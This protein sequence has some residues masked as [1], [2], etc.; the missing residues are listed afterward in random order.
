MTIPLYKVFMPE[1]LD[2]EIHNILYSGKLTFGN[3]GKLFEKAVQDFL[4]N[5]R[6]L[7]TNN[8][9]VAIQTAFAVLGL[10][11]GDEVIASPMS[12]L[13][14]NQP[15]LTSKLKVVWSD[16][17]PSTGTLD[18][19][20]LAKRISKRTKAIMHY[21]WCGNPGYVDEINSIAREYGLYVVEDATES[22]GSE[23]RGK[24]IGATGTD[25]VCFSFQPVRLPTTIEGGALA[26]S[27]DEL[28]RS[29]ILMRDYG[30]DRSKFRD[31]FGEI[32]SEC[33]IRLPGFHAMMPEINAYVGFGAMTSVPQL[34]EKQSNNM[35]FYSHTIKNERPFA[36]VRRNE[37]KGS[38][39][40]FT[41]LSDRS[42]E[43]LKLL[44][45]SGVY[46]SRVHL[47]NDHYSCFGP[48]LRT[49]L[50]G[51]N[52]FSAREIC[53]PSGWWLTENDRNTIV[54][55]IQSFR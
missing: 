16:I 2:E 53:V 4:A 42:S 48:N 29:A 7:A 41:I 47:R 35:S 43:L 27:S 52:E 40:V 23:Y 15:L 38:G 6:V 14:S 32:S 54:S 25:I 31:E 11:P 39:W 49:D 21:H 33:D 34:L 8:N 30:I 55:A 10:S 28:F 45:A 26:F 37:A 13:A 36:V 3:Y 17:D 46:A 5:P 24:K 18:P 12:C 1:G 51:V 50:K 9:N 44:R 22:F 20:D 19:G